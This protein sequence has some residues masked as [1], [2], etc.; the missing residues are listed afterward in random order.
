MVT[1]SAT[2]EV[3]RVDGLA[4]SLQEFTVLVVDLGGIVIGYDDGGVLALDDDADLGRLGRFFSGVV[5]LE[6]TELVR[7]AAHLAVGTESVDFGDQRRGSVIVDRD[8]GVWGLGAVDV[9]E[10]AADGDDFRGDFV[11]AEEPAGDIDF[12]DGLVAKVAAAVVPEPVPIVV[13]RASVGGFR[14]LVGLVAA[15]GFHDVGW[16]VP[17]IV[18]NGGRDLVLLGRAN[19]FAALVADGASELHFAVF[20]SVD[21]FDGGHDACARTALGASLDDLFVKVLGGGDELLTFKDIM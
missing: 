2:G 1:R 3:D 17:E 8:E 14:C 21:G 20:S 6:F 10:A 9:T 16:A 12:V 15:N 7:R 18:I 19:G 5:V 4:V 11:R 13:N